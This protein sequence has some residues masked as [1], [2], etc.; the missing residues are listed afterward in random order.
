LFGDG[1]TRLLHAGGKAVVT[2]GKDLKLCGQN[3]KKFSV[4]T[5]DKLVET[6]HKIRD[7]MRS[8]NRSACIQHARETAAKAGRSVASAAKTAYHSSKKAMASAYTSSR[9]W[10]SRKLGLDN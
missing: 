1:S 10:F 7:C 6:G 4:R 8:E 9:N 3:I 2:C 5:K